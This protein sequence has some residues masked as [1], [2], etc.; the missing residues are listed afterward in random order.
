MKIQLFIHLLDDK[1]EILNVMQCS[2][3]KVPVLKI[4]KIAIKSLNTSKK[5]IKIFLNNNISYLAT[6][7]EICKS[8][9]NFY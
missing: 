5:D 1:I 7:V 4:W 8:F 3:Q 6:F 9:E 2:S